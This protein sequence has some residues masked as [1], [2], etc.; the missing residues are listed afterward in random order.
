LAVHYNNVGERSNAECLYQQALLGWEKSLGPN[1]LQVAVAL[2][3]Y[4]GLLEEIGQKERSQALLTRAAQIR[5]AR[6]PT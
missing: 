2:E 1:D 5:S 4:S 6:H 3:S